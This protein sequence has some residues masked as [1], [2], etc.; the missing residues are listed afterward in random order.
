MGKF[1]LAI[2]VDYLL[3]VFYWYNTGCNGS[4]SI[5]WNRGTLLPLLQKVC[6]VRYAFIGRDGKSM[7]VISAHMID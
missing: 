1:Y 4:L 3:K 2:C 7:D 5:M 6:S